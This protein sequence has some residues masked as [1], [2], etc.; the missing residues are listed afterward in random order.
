MNSLS[1]GIEE[2]VNNINTNSYE[3]LNNNNLYGNYNI[4]NL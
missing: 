2:I 4:N 3:N 1:Q